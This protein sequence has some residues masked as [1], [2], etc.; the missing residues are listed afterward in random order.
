MKIRKIKIILDTNIWI[1]FL[2]TKDFK[3]LDLLI[4]RE[5][6]QLLFSNELLEE[7]IS[8]AQRPKFKRYFTKDDIEKLL[9]NFD[10]YGEIIEVK[11]DIKEC[12]DIKDNFLLNL[13]IDGKANYL[14]TG[15]NDLLNMHTI[16]NTKIVSI[17]DFLKIIK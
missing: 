3:K 16:Q 1:S 10:Y 2:I 13:A 7:F 17:T 4:K 8:V 6:I 14:I 5:K 15:D 12:R 9:D 11:S